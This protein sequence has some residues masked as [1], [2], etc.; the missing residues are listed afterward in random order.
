MLAS[1]QRKYCRFSCFDGKMMLKFTIFTKIV[2][3]RACFSAFVNCLP[4][5]IAFL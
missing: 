2:I 3:L 4:F 5:L 1:I